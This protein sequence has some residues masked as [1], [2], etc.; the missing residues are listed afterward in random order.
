MFPSIHNDNPKYLG[1]T[2]LFYS[3]ATDRAC[4][5]FCTDGQNLMTAWTTVRIQVLHPFIT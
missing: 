3:L 1:L 4:T 5:N 2:R